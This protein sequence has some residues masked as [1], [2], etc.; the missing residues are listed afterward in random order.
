[1]VS[2]SDSENMI[3]ISPRLGITHRFVQDTYFT[4]PA[5]ILGSRTIAQHRKHEINLFE[6]SIRRALDLDSGNPQARI[7]LLERL[8]QK[9]EQEQAMGLGKLMMEDP[10][11]RQAALELF[12]KR[13]RQ[14]KVYRILENS[15]TLKRTI[16]KK[17]N[18]QC[19]EENSNTV[20]YTVLVV[21][22]AVLGAWA[23]SSLFR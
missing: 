13:E 11:T 20:F 7:L 22:V 9:G 12:R 14:E 1:M 21:I 8:Q 3:S 23:F 2:R 18:G 19:E 15:E 5:R 10:E 17:D 16:E 4:T 6:S